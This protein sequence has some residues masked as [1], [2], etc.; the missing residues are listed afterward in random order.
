MHTL[1]AKSRKELGKKAK[2]LRNQGF[3]PAILYGWGMDG[4]HP[5]AVA[6]PDFERAWRQAGESAVLLLTLEGHAHNVIIHDVAHDP[7]TDKPI[8]ADFYAVAM[9][10]KI[11]TRVPL[12]FIGE[13]TAVKD[14]G[15]VLVKVMHDVEIEALPKDLPHELDADISSLLTLRARLLVHDISMP[16]SVIILAHADDVIAIVEPPRTEEELAALTETAAQEG[17][18]EVKTEQEVKRE[19]KESK[20]PEE[21]SP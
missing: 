8:H 2:S 20:T 19:T 12:N 1:D 9:D 14:L 13:S 7:I 3:V 10:K 15:G 17:V 16:D 21:T 11:R 5:I 6:M 4:A 18:A